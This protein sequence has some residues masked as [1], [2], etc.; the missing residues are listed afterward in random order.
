[1][2]HNAFYFDVWLHA[3]LKWWL[4]YPLGAIVWIVLVFFA[5][6]VFAYDDFFH[7][8]EL[9][10]CKCDKAKKFTLGPDWPYVISVFAAWLFSVVTAVKLWNLRNATHYGIDFSD[11][12]E[13]PLPWGSAFQIPSDVAMAVGVFARF[14]YAPVGLCA[15]STLLRIAAFVSLGRGLKYLAVQLVTVNAIYWLYGFALAF[16]VMPAPVGFYFFAQNCLVLKVIG[17]LALMVLVLL[18]IAL[19]AILPFLTGHWLVRGIEAV[20]F[21]RNPAI[22]HGIGWLPIAGSAMVA[23]YAAIPVGWHNLWTAEPA[24]LEFF[25]GPT[26]VWTA[27]IFKWSMTFDLPLGTVAVFSR[28]HWEIPIILAGAA[29]ILRIRAFKGIFTAMAQ[30]VLFSVAAY[31]TAAFFGAFYADLLF[32]AFIGLFVGVGITSKSSGHTYTGDTSLE[33]I[34]KE[35]ERR[36]NEEEERQRRETEKYNRTHKILDDGTW[37]GTEIEDHGMFGW[38]DRAGNKYTEHFD[39]TFSRDD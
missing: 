31:A 9:K 23:A 4:A 32:I 36:K 37:G 18:L 2:F 19:I 29:F 33:E 20:I 11:L 5:F 35:N 39:G 12:A 24:K 1:M 34:N 21:Y 14:W 17:K 28:M 7:K 26:A 30:F 27:K 13:C 38:I 10:T 15:I 6:F 22:Y 16:F 3:H 25:S 8:L